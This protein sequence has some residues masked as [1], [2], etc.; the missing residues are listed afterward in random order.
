MKILRIILAVAILFSTVFTAFIGGKKIAA[1]EIDKTPT[2]YRGVISLWQI[3]GFEGGVNSRKQFLLKI[4]RM[5]EKNNDGVLI[6]VTNQTIEGARESIKN[7][8]FPDLISF[9][10]GLDVTQFTELKIDRKSSSGMVGEKCFAAVWCKGGYCL[11]SNTQLTQDLTLE[12]IDSLIVSQG[13]YTQP[14]TALT[15]QGVKA[16]NVEVYSPMDAY[17]K[18]VAGKSPYFLATQ[19]DVHRLINRGFDFD[20]K[21]L[22]AYNDLF[23]YVAITT[24]DQVKKYFAQDFVEFLLAD[25]QQALLTQIGLF[26]DFVTLD[27]SDDRLC[28]FQNLK[29]SFTVSAFTSSK[30]LKEMQEISLSACIGNLSAINKIKN[31]LI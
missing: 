17:V 5:Y 4:A 28:A 19:R 10:A 12:N 6:M 8:V 24:N 3:D 18:F 14:L 20:V 31:M 2:S 25:E 23:Q 11:I 26:S 1:D 29:H 7:G 13:D 27:Y 15:M 21:P 16:N 22:S 30:N 9:S